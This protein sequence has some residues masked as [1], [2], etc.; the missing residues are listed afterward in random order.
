VTIFFLIRHGTN[1]LIESNILAGRAPAVHLNDQGRRQAEELAGYLAQ[2]P[3]TAIYSSPLERT[4]E[5]AEPLARRLGKSV[6]VLP[7]I[8][9]VEFGN[10]TGRSFD[11]LSNDPRWRS[12][13]LA[14]SSTRIPSGEIILE[15]QLRMIVALERLR[16]EHPG[17][18]VALVSHGDPI[19][20][21]VAH[22]LNM[23]LD[24][25]LRFTVSPA[26]VSLVDFTYDVPQVLCLNSSGL[27]LPL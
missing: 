22:C 4:M 27:G 17:E 20:S 15:V 11:A 5:T 14:R 18:M 3:L 21:V 2:Q 8:N 13:N 24:A 25:I 23:P 10:W 6:Q 12:F 16:E 19:R 26:S 1:D 9:E 7:D